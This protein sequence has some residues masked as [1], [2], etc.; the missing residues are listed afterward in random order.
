MDALPQDD[1]VTDVAPWSEEL[2]AYDKAHLKVYIRLLDAKARGAQP[3]EVCKVLFGI[4]SA[5]EPDRARKTYET[6]LRRAV[7]FT[8]VGYRKLLED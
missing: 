5:K 1:M 2:T 3:D 6:H 7:W 8:E 4:N